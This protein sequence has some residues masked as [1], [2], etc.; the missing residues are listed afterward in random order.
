[1]QNALVLMTY[2]KDS[3][4]FAILAHGKLVHGY[5][6]YSCFVI[7]IYQV[8][9]DQFSVYNKFAMCMFKLYFI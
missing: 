6:C 9:R 7:N 8:L 2:L 5:H 3:Y 1:M 4:S